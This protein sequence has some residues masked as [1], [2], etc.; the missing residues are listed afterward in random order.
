[1]GKWFYDGTRI[2][3]AE[4]CSLGRTG[5]RGEYFV[6]LKMKAITKAYRDFGLG[7][8]DGAW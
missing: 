7:E 2:K 8:E 3:A 6:V 5:G 1:M 4:F